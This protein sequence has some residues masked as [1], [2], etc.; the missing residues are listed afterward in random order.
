MNSIGGASSLAALHSATLIAR[1][2]STSKGGQSAQKLPQADNGNSAS[3][4]TNKTA[5]GDG[6]KSPQ[7]KP[8]TPDQQKEIQELKKR[9]AAV[10]RHEQ[11][12]LSAAGPYA[13]SGAVFD[14]QTG[15]DGKQYA[16]GGHVDI[17]AGAVPG[18]PKATIAKAEQVKRAA[19]APADPS[20]QDRAVAAQAAS[21]EATARAQE[22]QKSQQGDN[23]RPAK[24][25]NQPGAI[26]G[27]QSAPS[28]GQ[29]ID[30]RS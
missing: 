16:V 17:D 8:L 13:K 15:P 9:D 27:Y 4:S 7:G 14:Y 12:H 1:S 11:A 29:L 23:A 28:V 25:L 24:S 21:T 3:Q 2:R 10:R 30:A 5:G 19:L 22:A 20:A 26:S 6:E 18:D